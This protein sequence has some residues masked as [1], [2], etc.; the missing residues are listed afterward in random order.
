MKHGPGFT[1]AP[2]QIFDEWM[3]ELGFAE[4]KVVLCVTRLTFGWRKGSDR[5]SLRQICEMTGLSRSNAIEAVRSLVDRG[6]LE[7]IRDE[8]PA[9]SHIATLYQLCIGEPNEQ[10]ASLEEEASHAA[11]LALVTEHDQPGD[12]AIP[13]SPIESPELV[14]QHDQASHAASPGLV[15]QHDHQH[16]RL[17]TKDRHT[18]RDLS[19]PE[20]LEKPGGDE[21]PGRGM[22]EV[23]PVARAREA[24]DGGG[25]M[26]MTPSEVWEAVQPMLMARMD[27]RDG[28]FLNHIRLAESS[29]DTLR[30]RAR[31]EA[32]SRWVDREGGGKLERALAEALGTRFKVEFEPYRNGASDGNSGDQTTEANGIPR[33]GHLAGRAPAAIRPGQPP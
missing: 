12:A 21:Y 11:G 18:S 22:P 4:L 3:K 17:Q 33:R 10:G 31:S 19:A 30:F 26:D 29:G 8:D 27:P 14:T 15:T 1:Q 5:I 7:T 6:A 28:Q 23:E 25:E 2:D 20:D 13:A 32:A 24:P 16:T 9:R